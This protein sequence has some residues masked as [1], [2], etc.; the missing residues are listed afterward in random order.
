MLF[1]PKMVLNPIALSKIS[2]FSWNLD[3]RF[4]TPLQ[5]VKTPHLG[6]KAN[7][8]NRKNKRF[9][10]RRNLREVQLHFI[11]VHDKI[12]KRVGNFKIFE[13]T[14]GKIPWKGA[15]I[16]FRGWL[17]TNA[18][19]KTLFRAEPLLYSWQFMENQNED[20]GR[21]IAF[22][23]QCSKFHDKIASTTREIQEKLFFRR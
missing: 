22:L 4:F 15:K 3:T 12:L 1:L 14:I 21:G 8:D 16:N 10:N 6:F 19:T 5:K 17:Y 2:L 11:I 7:A 23:H 13:H 9:F 20:D 18:N